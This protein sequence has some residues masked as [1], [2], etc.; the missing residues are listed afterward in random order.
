MMPIIRTA[1]TTAMTG[2]RQE[3]SESRKFIRLCESIYEV[4]L[5]NDERF[6]ATLSAQTGAVAKFQKHRGK[7]FRRSL[8]TRDRKLA[9]RRLSELRAKVG[10]LQIS[11]DAKLTFAHAGKM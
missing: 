8:K 6:L 5:A 1:P 9:D 7:Q 4:R 3:G 11:A 2:R 10:G